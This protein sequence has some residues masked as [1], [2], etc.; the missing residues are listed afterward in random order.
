MDIGSF[1]ILPHFLKMS[2]VNVEFNEDLLAIATEEDLANEM[3]NKMDALI[4]IAK[5]ILSFIKQRV[6]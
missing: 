5:N 6:K 4:P 3:G 1:I 2:E